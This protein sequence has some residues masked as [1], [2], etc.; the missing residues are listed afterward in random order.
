LPPFF[1]ILFGLLIV[2]KAEP[3][4]VARKQA[5]YHHPALKPATILSPQNFEQ[6]SKLGYVVVEGYIDYVATSWPEDDGDYHFEMQNTKKLHDKPNP[7]DGLVCEIDPVL[8][9]KT[10]ETLRKIKQDD[11]TTYRKVRVFGWLRFGTE[12]NHAGVQDY[13]FGGNKPVNGHWE[14][15]PVEKI[16]TIDNGPFFSLG[17]AAEY[18][19][20]PK[21][22]KGTIAK[23]YKVNDEKFADANDPHTKVSNYAKL[24][25]NVKKIKSAPND[26]RDLDVDFEV[27]STIYL[28]T[29]PEYYIESFNPNTETVK[30]RQLTNFKL[31]NYTLK[32]SDSKVRT[33]YGL[34][35]WRF[36]NG[37]IFPTLAPVEMV[38]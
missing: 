29:I 20:W 4:A 35:A 11:P 19:K 28:A 25:G 10:A 7:K 27:N 30:F 14:I 36:N 22:G 33:F 1:V 34:R 37:K 13:D 12:R 23:R 8:Q 26:S 15:H 9:P 5:A 16:E 24:V 31:V 21:Q 6:M 3:L 17:P 32:P 38:K 2:V 18:L